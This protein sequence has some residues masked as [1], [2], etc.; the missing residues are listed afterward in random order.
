MLPL[1]VSLFAGLQSW[2]CN[3]FAQRGTRSLQQRPSFAGRLL[4]RTGIHRGWYST[5]IIIDALVACGGDAATLNA[6][7][8]VCAQIPAVL[9]YAAV[10]QQYYC[11]V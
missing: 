1:A 5:G 2:T 10:Q 9:L 3:S 4:E 11:T 8:V 7:R 6:L